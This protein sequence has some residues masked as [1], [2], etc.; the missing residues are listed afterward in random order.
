MKRMLVLG[1]IG[2]VAIFVA[3]AFAR[4]AEVGPS[5]GMFLGFVFI[6]GVIVGA[7]VGVSAGLGYFLGE[8][9][10]KYWRWA[11]AFGAA[12]ATAI[13]GAVFVVPN[14]TAFTVTAALVA[15][16]AAAVAGSIPRSTRPWLSDE[17]DDPVG[18]E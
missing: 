4:R 17:D 5:E 13:W 3:G 6:I 11:P 18:V 12:L 2:G 1:V 16:L 8:R 9:L 15:V 7:A 10:A 14:P